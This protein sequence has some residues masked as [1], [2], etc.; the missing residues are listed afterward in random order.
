MESMSDNPS[1]LK[2]PEL[3]A[4]TYKVLCPSLFIISLDLSSTFEEM[5]SL[6]EASFGGLK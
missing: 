5:S 2:C 3:R 6:R 4:L 1:T